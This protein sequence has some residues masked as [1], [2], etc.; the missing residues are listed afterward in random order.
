MKQVDVNEVFASHGMSPVEAGLYSVA[1]SEDAFTV[2]IDDEPELMFGVCADGTI[3]MLSSDRPFEKQYREQFMA[4]SVEWVRLFHRRFDR[5]H[6][7]VDARNKRSI[8][9]LRKIGFKVAERV[10]AFGVSGIPF[11][12]MESRRE[13]CV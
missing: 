12:L 11:V 6:N 9:W 13:S 4:E 2:F 1:N 5:L 8:A 10:P 7:Y 3:W